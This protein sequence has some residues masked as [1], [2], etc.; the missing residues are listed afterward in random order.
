MKKSKVIRLTEND[1]EKIV[2]K[3]LRE[4]DE[5]EWAQDS[6]ESKEGFDWLLHEPLEN[7][8][9]LQFEWDDNLYEIFAAFDA[10]ERWDEFEYDDD[11]PTEGIWL[12]TLDPE[13]GEWY[14][15]SIPLV[16]LVDDFNSGVANFIGFNPNTREEL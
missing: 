4:N 8:V 13:T 12:N 3:L 5:L 14:D 7:L 15:E 6:L 10:S 11:E 9:G 16:S 2:K 1:L